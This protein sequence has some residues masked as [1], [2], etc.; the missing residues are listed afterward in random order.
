MKGFVGKGSSG[1]ISECEKKK[2][3]VL[4]INTPCP[5]TFQNEKKKE[6]PQKPSGSKWLFVLQFK[7]GQL[8]HK[9][10]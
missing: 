2:K 10:I 9:Y 1:Y 8:P 5:D 3:S 7:H 4:I 6:Q